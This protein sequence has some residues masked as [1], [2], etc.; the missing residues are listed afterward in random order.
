MRTIVVPPKG[1]LLIEGDYS[2][3]ELFTLAN[4]SGDPNMLKVLNTP[5]MDLHDKSAVDGFGF[6]MEDED[7]NEVTLE[8]LVR[9]AEEEKDNGGEE[10]ER[11][12]HLQKSL[13]YISKDGHRYTRSQFKSGPRIAAKAISFSVPYGISANSLGYN[14][15]SQTG[16]PRDLGVITAEVAKL[17]DAWKNKSFPIAWQ[18]L[19]SWQNKVDDPGWIENPWGRRKWLTTR[20]GQNTSAL[21]REAGNYNMQ[22]TVSDTIQIAS[23]RLLRRRKEL[24]LKFR[25]QNQIH[26]ALM[27]EVPME[28]LE[29]TKQT[30]TWAMSEIDIPTFTP[31]KTFRLACD[32]DE[33]VRWGEKRH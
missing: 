4:L 16:D 25:L 11:F 17:M 8:D 7:G 32:I 3:A 2:Q 15:K 22:S 5:G 26:D 14:V 18:H 13:S 31:G 33:Y 30:L 10:S 12:Q 19:V 20:P 27:L 9:V 29:I 28:E 1:W 23:D 24:G 21:K 6:H